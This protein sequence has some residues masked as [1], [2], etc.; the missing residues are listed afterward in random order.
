LLS[1]RRENSELTIDQ[2]ITDSGE[3]CAGDAFYLLTD[4][5]AAWFLLD[6]EQGGSP[7]ETLSSLNKRSFASF[8][9]DRRARGL[10]RNDDVAVVALNVRA[11]SVARRRQPPGE[12]T[13]APRRF[14]S[15]RASP[16]PDLE[17]GRTEGEG[18]RC[19]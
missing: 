18:R 12:S 7:W 14:S 6:S 13:D 1:T 5:I 16:G 10:M 8:V 3:W 11:S 2:L 9:N 15:R 17:I 4:A 19:P